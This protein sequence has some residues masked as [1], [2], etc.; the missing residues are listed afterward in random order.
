LTFEP[1][2]PYLNCAKNLYAF[3]AERRMP[4]GVVSIAAAFRTFPIWVYAA[5]GE[6]IG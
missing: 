1:P 5:I 2:L 4:A 6:V 3:G